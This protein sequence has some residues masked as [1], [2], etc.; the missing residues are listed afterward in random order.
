MG[1]DPLCQGA[2]SYDR[3]TFFV[4]GPATWNLFRDNLCE[5]DMYIDSFR[6]TLK[7]I[8]FEQYSARR[9]HCDDALYNNVSTSPIRIFTGRIAA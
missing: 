6:R 7:T 5:P 1:P 8:L 2:G 3:R 4:A 9:A